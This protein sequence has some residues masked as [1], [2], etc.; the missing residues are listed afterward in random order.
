MEYEALWA[1]IKPWLP[2]DTRGVPRVDDHRVV[3][4]I[5]WR[6]WPTV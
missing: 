6:A 3:S 1:L 5:A 4:G 2:T